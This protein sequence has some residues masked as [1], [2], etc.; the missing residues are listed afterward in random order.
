MYL[1]KIV[2]ENKKKFDSIF[3]SILDTRKLFCVLPYSLLIFILFSY[4]IKINKTF[5]YLNLKKK[6]KK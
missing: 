3:P 5:K 4:E 6:P 1:Y 2:K